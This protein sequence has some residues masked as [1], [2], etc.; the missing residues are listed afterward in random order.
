M[1][2]IIVGASGWFTLQTDPKTKS[3]LEALNQAVTIKDEKIFVLEEEIKWMAV[4]VER[5]INEKKELLMKS[6]SNEENEVSRRCLTDS[7]C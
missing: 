2:I 6:S 7:S 5:A 3:D 1:R 4:K